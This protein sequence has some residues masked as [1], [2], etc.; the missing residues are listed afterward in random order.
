MP[1]KTLEFTLSDDGT[2]DTVIEVH[3]TKCKRTWEER[4][5]GESA[6]D[7]RDHETGAMIGLN[8]LVA[9]YDICCTCEE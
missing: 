9:E 5:N 8:D 4:F 3:C 1:D 2:L 6:L 7:Y